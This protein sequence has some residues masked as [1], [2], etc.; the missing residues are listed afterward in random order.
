MRLSTRLGAVVAALAT[1]IGLAAAPA[2]AS[3]THP[4]LY[5]AAAGGSE[6]KAANGLVTSGLTAASGIQGLVLPA[7]N[8]NDI[9]DTHVGNVLSTG[10]ITTNVSAQSNGPGATLTAHS[11][12]LGVNL[13]NGLITAD[14][15][16]TTATANFDGTALTGT[17]ATTLA[18]IKISNIDIPI[19]IPR[20]F[21]VNIPNVARIVLNYSHVFTGT[22][23]ETLSA[24]AAGIYV[25]LLG[26]FGS[27][28]LGT[29]IVVNPSYS[30]LTTHIPHAPVLL[31]G[32]AY[33]TRLS[34]NALDIV[35]INSGRTAFQSL[36]IG[37]TAG[38]VITN[39]TAAVNIPQVLSTGVVETTVR[40]ART[41]VSGDA[42][43]TAEVAQLSL[44]NDLIKAD[45]IKSTAHVHV[46]S[47][48]TTT[49]TDSVRF[50]G[51]TIDGHTYPVTVSPNTTINVLGLGTVTLNQQ[52][53]NSFDTN[54]R[55]ILIKL[56]TARA[57]LPVGA[58]IEVAFASAFVLS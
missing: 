8:S 48:G 40:G 55:A 36:G 44:F 27:T 7:S 51:L 2:A 32:S 1:T 53:G 30:A 19:N 47:D 28:P 38:Q 17:A 25:T 5:L 18:N 37:G 16:E 3:A 9:A 6:V 26:D 22:G 20:N 11:K 13:L 23:G 54:V 56:S 50:V 45:A 21:T 31:G 24:Q 10:A 35:G 29:V 42:R 58:V 46:A 43:T 34:V 14:V 4:V 39:S 49:I 57:G 15:A 12:T 52:F 41:N 33:G